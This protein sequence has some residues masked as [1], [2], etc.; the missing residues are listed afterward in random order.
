[1]IEARNVSFAYRKSAPS[2]LKDV[3]C[4]I[5]QGDIVAILGLNGSGKSTFIKLLVGLE[6]AKGGEILYGGR[7]IGKI[8]FHDRS[9]LFAYVSQKH[10]RV[11]G[12]SV[13]EYLS[14]GMANQ[15][16]FYESPGEEEEERI[17]DIAVRF[18]IEH[19]LNKKINQISGGERQL[20][21]ICAALLQNSEAIILDEPTSALDYA[22]QRN[23]LSALKEIAK[24]GKTI[25]LST[26]NPNHALFLGSKVLLLSKGSVAGYGEAKDIITVDNLKPIYGEGICLSK[27]LDYQ[28]ISFRS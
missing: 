13:K 10:S 6:K 28:E 19:L 7:S 22:N 11:V 9:K 24:E 26:H 1:M 14:F 15:L 2:V 21:A 4:K 16:D 12:Y 23:V 18:H 5:H 27:D 8:N 17:S 20:V 25:V 3:S